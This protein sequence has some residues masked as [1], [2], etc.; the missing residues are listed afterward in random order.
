MS[1]HLDV[2]RADD[3]GSGCVLSGHLGAFGAGGDG[4]GGGCVLSGHLGVF[5]DDIGGCCSGFVLSVL[6]GV[7][8]GHLGV[9]GA[10]SGGGGGFVIRVEAI[11]KQLYCSGLFLNEVQIML[12]LLI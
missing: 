9:C 8:S 2:C 1:G 5:G 12:L 11:N 7:V 6:K 10:D 3:S 4:G